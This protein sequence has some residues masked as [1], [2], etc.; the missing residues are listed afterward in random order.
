M[1]ES[2]KFKVI[3]NKKV[4]YY[5]NLA[6][7][8]EDLRVKYDMEV[9]RFVPGYKEFMIPTVIT[10]LKSIKNKDKI[11][12]LG[13]GTGGLSSLIFKELNP[14]KMIWLDENKSMVEISQEVASSEKITPVIINKSLEDYVFD[15]KFDIVHSSLTLH[16]ISNDIENQEIKKNVIKKIFNSLND[17]G[18]F[19]WTDLVYFEDKEMQKQA[20]D[21]RKKYALEKG[22]D[23]TFIEEN[24]KKELEN[25]FPLTIEESEKILKEIGFTEIK[26]IWESTT[27]ATIVAKK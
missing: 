1:E 15:E 19:V 3:Q 13:C 6:D 24:F 10:F 8:F 2:N 25:D 14:K 27:F 17:Q 23:K 16:N 20:V 11:I 12:D 18:V 26:K 22:A 7:K 4:E 9:N 21:Y 5:N